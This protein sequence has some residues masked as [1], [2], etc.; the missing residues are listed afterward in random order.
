MTQ[1]IYLKYLEF[2][3][4]VAHL[5]RYFS[6]EQLYQLNLAQI[7]QNFHL[8]IKFGSLSTVVGR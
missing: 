5:Y 8:S 2:D 1:N 6:H 7:Y 4:L 3:Y